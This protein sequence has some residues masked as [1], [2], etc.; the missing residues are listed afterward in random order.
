MSESW[1]LSATKVR[2]KDYYVMLSRGTYEWVHTYERVTQR[3]DSLRPYDSFCKSH[4]K[5]SHE[6]KSHKKK[7]H[8]KKSHK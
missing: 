3:Y 4:K 8:E 6:K 2:A 5:K 1:D 7:S